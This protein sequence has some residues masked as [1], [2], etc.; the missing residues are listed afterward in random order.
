MCPT[1]HTYLE[2]DCPGCRQRPQ[3]HPGWLSRPIELWRCPAA[4]VTLHHEAGGRRRRPWCTYDLRT[5]EAVPARPEETAAQQLLLGWADDPI[6]ASIACGTTITGRIGFDAM[7]DLF[8]AATPAAPFDLTHQPARVAARL[9]DAAHVL[10]QPTLGTAAAAAARLL[11]YSGPHAPLGP[12]SRIVDHPYNPLLAA[13]QLHGVRDQLGPADQLMFRTG[14]PAPR[15]PATPAPK[16]R[17]RLRLPDHQPH[18]PEPD[19]YRLPQKIWPDLLPEFL[20]TGPVRYLPLRHAVLAM[21]L[22]KIGNAR[23]W[24]QIATDLDLPPALAT[25]VGTVLQRI[26]RHGRW[27]ATLSTLDALVSRLQAQPAP[28]DYAARRHAGRD[29]G[30]LRR[31]LEVAARTHPTDTPADVVLRHFWELFT[32]GDIA[33][34]PDLIHISAHSAR[35]RRYRTIAART[36]DQDRALLQVAHHEV[37]RL[38]DVGPLTG[39]LTWTPVEP[40][41]IYADDS[42]HIVMGQAM[43]QPATLSAPF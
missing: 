7:L 32:G 5:V 24:T 43:A 10:T 17:R 3:H 35:Y 16:N 13:L 28:V 33:Y 21:A 27:P 2:L 4:L 42:V 41:A 18:L 30:S 34:A 31:A 37:G 23:T 39:P 14:H 29:V 36:L 20:L 12:P 19:P 38:T 26:R 11:S 25:N 15:Y 1:H 40:V 9:A 22:A 6:G 8:D